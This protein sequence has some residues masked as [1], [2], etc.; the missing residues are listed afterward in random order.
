MVNENQYEIALLMPYREAD[1]SPLSYFY[2]SNRTVRVIASVVIVAFL[3]FQSRP[4]AAAFISE[5]TNST[6]H[7]KARQEDSHDDMSHVLDRTAVTLEHF[8]AELNKNGDTSTDKKDLSGLGM[9]LAALGQKAEAD[10]DRVG[11]HIRDR[12]L[13]AVI[14]ARHEKAL[15]T[16]RARLSAF[17]GTVSRIESAKNNSDRGVFIKKALAQLKKVQKKRPYERL[18]PKNLPFRIPHGKVRKPAKTKAGYQAAGLLSTGSIQVASMVLSPAML[19]PMSAQAAPTPADLAETEDVQITP[20]IQKLANALDKNPVSIFTWVHDNIDYIPTYGSIQGAAVT[21]SSHRGNSFDTASLLIALLRASGIPAR[22]VYGTVDVPVKQAMNWVGGVSTPAAAL[23]LFGQGGI[24]STGL[25]SGGE[26]KAIEL[27]HVWVEAWVDFNPSRGAVNKDAHTWVPLDASFKQYVYGPGP[28]LNDPSF[29]DMRDHINSAIQTA[30]WNSQDSSISGIDTTLFDSAL[31]YAHD[32]MWKVFGENKQPIA[33]KGVENYDDPV[34]PTALPYHVVMVGSRFDEFSDP[35]RPKLWFKL[36][37]NETDRLLDDPVISYQADLVQV[38]GKT[39]SVA[40]V[41]ATDADKQVIE[42]YTSNVQPGQPLDPTKLPNT[43]P[44]YLIHVKAQ[45]RL[46]GQVVQK[47]GT[48]TLGDELVSTTSIS[49]LSGGKITAGHTL[50]AGEQ[51]VI[52][53]DLQ[54]V[55]NSQLIGTL[56]NQPDNPIP[57]MAAAYF[58]TLDNLQIAMRGVGGAVVV[59]QPSFGIFTTRLTPQLSYGIPTNVDITGANID[60]GAVAY[61][62]VPLN[63]DMSRTPR[64]A[65][66]IGLATS[67]LEYEIPPLYTSNTTYPEG[68]ISAVKAIGSAI[69][70]GQK[71]YKVDQGNVDTALTSLSVSSDVKSD[72]LTATSAGLTVIIPASNITSGR[73]SGTGYIVLD[74]KTGS[75]AYRISGGVNGGDADGGFN[76]ALTLTG[77]GVLAG[78]LIPNAH[79][80][81]GDCDN[82]DEENIRT[83]WSEVLFWVLFGAILAALIYGGGEVVLAPAATAAAYGSLITEFIQINAAMASEEGLG[84][85]RYASGN[86]VVTTGGDMSEITTHIN[87]AQG[88]SP[89]GS[90]KYL[91]WLGPESERSLNVLIGDDSGDRDWYNKTDTCSKG[92]RIKFALDHDDIPG[93]CDEYPFFSTLEGGELNYY[94]RPGTVSL[95]MV[96]SSQNKRQGATLGAF[97]SKCGLYRLQQYK[98]EAITNTGSTTTGYD[99]DGVVCYP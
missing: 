48:Y 33:V 94:A 1:V 36:Y 89:M 66:I 77:L 73:W 22:Y 82:S 30:Q 67:T 19:A 91:T 9:T 8:Q 80:E 23:Q 31:T 46:D 12:H 3:L 27:E 97:Y 87:D 85:P 15:A 26:I 10:F 74:E 60:I 57:S 55:P 35:M 58:A 4:V 49:R 81:S 39:L 11:R 62:L 20:N 44:G 43:L 59:Q 40:F 84:C 14:M 75:A 2:R 34:L 61:S 70:E 6:T 42:S 96:T 93:N 71:I 29:S 5:N 63:G 28:N 41:A 50:V 98:V 76:N 37:A 72:I 45:L 47:G 24:P 90:P 38:A 25:V 51:A 17:L 18:D 56:N 53:L 32:N 88:G 65:E 54:G 16:Y 79:A 21:L 69:M 92:K 64:L 7:H 52:G 78:Y 95:K 68:S 13:P 99:K 86:V 83:T